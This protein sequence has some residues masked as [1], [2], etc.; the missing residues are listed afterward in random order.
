MRK[1]YSKIIVLLKTGQR[2]KEWNLFLKKVE[3]EFQDFIRFFSQIFIGIMAVFDKSKKKKNFW[4]QNKPK[5]NRK[6]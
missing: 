2:K 6:E 5:L 4:K 1:Q 3:N